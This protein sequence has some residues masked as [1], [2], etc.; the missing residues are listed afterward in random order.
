MLVVQIGAVGVAGKSYFYTNLLLASMA[1]E[2]LEAGELFK[3][4]Q[5]SLVLVS[6]KLGSSAVN[7]SP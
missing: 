1:V 6:L 2:S 5:I 3:E 4:F 7:L